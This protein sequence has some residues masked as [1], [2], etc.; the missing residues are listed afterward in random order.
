[1]NEGHPVQALWCDPADGVVA[2]IVRALAERQLHAARTVVLV[3]YAQ[4]MGVARAMWA[5]CGSPGFV[6]RFETTHNWARSAGGFMPTGYDIAHDMARD[7]VTAQAL[8]SQAG[9]HAERFALAGRLVELAYQLAPLAAAATP[10]ERGGEWAQRAAGV[11]DAGSESEWFRIESALIRIAVAWTS[12]SSY[13]TDVLQ[14]ESTRAQ[15]D[16]LIVLE[17]FQA[18][19]LTVAVQAVGRP[20]PSYFARAFRCAHAG[21][22]LAYR[23]RPGR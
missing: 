5:R 21:L 20:C 18:D 19:P 16:A 22:C 14:R 17:G 6:P 1:M 3:P 2:R 15:V 7:L 11:A 10:E 8:L 4:L 9:F 13:A 23:A 12:T